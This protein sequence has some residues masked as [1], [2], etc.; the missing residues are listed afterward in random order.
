MSELSEWPTLSLGSPSD[1]EPNL[2]LDTSEEWTGPIYLGRFSLSSVCIIPEESLEELTSEVTQALSDN[3]TSLPPSRTSTPLFINLTTTLQTKSDMTAKL[4]MPMPLSP[5]T[6]KWDG[7]SRILRNFLRIMEQLFQT[8]EITEDQKK[9][10]W[11]TGYVDVDI[12][13]QWTSFEEYEAGSWNRF[14]E[15]LKTEY[16]ELTTE[17][18]SS[19]DNL[20]KLCRENARINLLEEERLMSFKRRF[21][22][23]AQKCLRPPAVAGNRE[24]V[25]LFVKTLDSTF[26]DALNSRLSIQ[27]T[28]KVDTQGR[29]HIEDPYDLDHIVQKAIELISRKTIAQAL[30]HMPVILSRNGKVDPDTRGPVY[31]S[32]EESVRKVE[33]HPDVEALQQ[34]INVLKTLYEKQERLQEH[35][36]KSVQGALDSIKTLIHSQGQT[37]APTT[38]EV[39][40]FPMR[41]G[42]G[43]PQMG[44]ARPLRKCFYCFETDHLFLFCPKKTEDE[45][46]GLIL[47]DKFMVRFANGEPIPMEHN[48]S[49]KD[50]VRKHLPSSIAVMMWGDPGLETCS[51]WDQEPDTGEIMVL[52]QLV[53]RQMEAPSREHGQLEELSHLRKKVGSLEVMLQKIS[54]EREPTPELEEEGMESFLRRMAAEY[55]Q[56]RQ[57]SAPRKKSGF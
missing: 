13:D 5:S 50:C 22:Y 51:V 25:E 10:D 52:S 23:I 45:K 47:V 6:P 28:L 8:A 42:Q 19:M 26:Q 40:G 21:V 31:Y 56:T 34:D 53:R 33:A 15:R 18:Q 35:H 43:P 17:E 12:H 30:K 57:D 3:L 7:Q 4:N 24:L 14:L 16:P 49:I 37:S 2:F 29:S 38:K 32:K 46:K 55:V 54:L 11:I 9:L 41:Y 27:G 48:M 1:V 20:R 39:G 44:P 36:E